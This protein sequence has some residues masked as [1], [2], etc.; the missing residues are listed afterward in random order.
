MYIHSNSCAKAS[1]SSP[2]LHQNVSML[3]NRTLNMWLSYAE[4]PKVKSLPK[5]LAS[6]KDDGIRTQT[7]QTQKFSCQEMTGTGIFKNQ[8]ESVKKWILLAPQF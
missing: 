7:A 5:W 8:L 4:V 6:L 1:T 2:L 3:R